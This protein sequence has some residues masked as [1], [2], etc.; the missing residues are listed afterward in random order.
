MTETHTGTMLPVME[1]FYTIQ[2]EGNFQ[3]S[4]AYF[5]RLGVAMWAA[6]GVT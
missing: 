1:S 5:I 4:A 3:G 6:S 2:G